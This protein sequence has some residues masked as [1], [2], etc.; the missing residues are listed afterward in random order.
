MAVL[1]SA[2]AKLLLFRAL[3]AYA[4]NKDAARPTNAIS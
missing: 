3:E 4:G 1:H 2:V